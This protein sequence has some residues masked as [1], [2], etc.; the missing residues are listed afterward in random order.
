MPPLPL[1]GLRSVT[2]LGQ[3]TADEAF[4]QYIGHMVRLPVV[5]LG[6]W[7][8]ARVWIEIVPRGE[9]QV[10]NLSAV[11]LAVGYSVTAILIFTLQSGCK[12]MR[13]PLDSLH[14]TT[15]LAGRPPRTRPALLQTST[16]SQ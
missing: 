11:F 16:C 12:C 7:L 6:L 9:L 5:W 8:A 13:V 15:S 14:P 4:G 1:Q 10:D 2:T 3:M